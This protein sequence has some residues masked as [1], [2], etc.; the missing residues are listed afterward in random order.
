MNRLIKRYSSASKIFCVFARILRFSNTPYDRSELKA[1]EVREAKVHLIKFAQK[2]MIKD[3][4]EAAEEGKGRSYRK[5][6]PMLDDK[7]VWRVGSRL[8]NHVPF[9]FDQKLPIL[10]PHDHRITYLVM[11]ESHRTHHSGYDGTLN[12]FRAEGYWT[13]RAA[14][15]ARNVKNKCVPC[16]KVDTKKTLCQPMGDFPPEIHV[17][18]KAW[19]YCQLDL[20]GPFHCRGDVNPRTT[21]KIWGMIVED[22]NSGAVHVDIV[23][24]YSADAVLLSLR[25]LGS[26][27]GWP[28]TMQSD[29]GSQLV[30]AS[31]KLES[32]WKEFE[33]V[34]QRFATGKNFEWKVS[35][36]DS[37]WRSTSL[38]VVPTGP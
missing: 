25:R 31:G 26:L 17:Q 35:P 22:V 7:G 38:P 18:P 29:P 28:G 12:R 21:K 5:L 2:G 33:S 15:L 19:G 4:K 6:A 1:G 36:P 30:S 13:V 9:T 23:M 8:K 37:P 32:W 27:R 11:E 24:D 34:L 20:F 10:L 16:R 3:L 14:Y